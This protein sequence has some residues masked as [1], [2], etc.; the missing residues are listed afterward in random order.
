MLGGLSSKL[1]SE[2]LAK[3]WITRILTPA[4]AF[5]AGGLLVWV[6][7]S[8][9]L[10]SWICAEL[11]PMKVAAEP[12][13]VDRQ[14][15]WLCVD[16]DANRWQ[17]LV[18]F[19][20]G[21]NSAEYVALTVGGLFLLT[22]SGGFATWLEFPILQ[23]LEGYWPGPL[24]KLRFKLVARL[25]EKLDTKRK[26]WEKLYRQKEELSRQKSKLDARQREIYGRLD[27]E[28]AIYPVDPDLRLPTLL[29]NILRG[30]EEYVCQRYGL[31]I[32]VVWPHL[33]LLVPEQTRKELSYTRQVLDDR[34]LLLAWSLLFSVWGIFAWWAVPVAFFTA[35]AIYYFGVLAAVRDYAPLLRATFDLHRFTLYQALRWPLPSEASEE[36]HQGEWLT[37]YL[38]RGSY[39]FRESPKPVVFQHPESRTEDQLVK[40]RNFNAISHLLLRRLRRSGS[41]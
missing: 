14:L 36:E 1:L 31:E 20:L 37:G 34:V 8:D 10:L 27:A 38:F 17:Q 33:W 21:L 13:A 24:A 30:A 41:L 16:G 19:L 22:I 25:N 23:L 4:L 5:W 40:D 29:G 2:G 6:C 39:L 35:I 12:G 18:S 11:T 9:G 32:T 7:N 15:V 26:L 3:A 28:L